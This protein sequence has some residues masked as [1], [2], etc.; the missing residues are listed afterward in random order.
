MSA[1][2]YT[3]TGTMAATTFSGSGA[4][5]TSIPRAGIANGT[6]DYVVINNGTGGLSSEA[7]LATSRGGLGSSWGAQAGGGVGNAAIAA[8]VGAATGTIT[9]LS[10]ATAA[11]AS[12][13]AIRDGSGNIA[14]NG[15]TVAQKLTIDN[16]TV[17]V[18]Y[19]IYTNPTVITTVGATSAALLTYSLLTPAHAKAVD[20]DLLVTANDVTHVANTASYRYLYRG[21]CVT[22]TMVLTLQP[23]ISSSVSYDATLATATIACTAS[24]SNFLVTVTGIALTTIVW[25]AV[26]KITQTYDLAGINEESSDDSCCCSVPQKVEPSLSEIDKA[27]KERLTAKLASFGITENAQSSSSSPHITISSAPVTLLSE[28]ER[29]ARARLAV[30]SIGT[31]INGKK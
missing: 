3:F 17:G 23:V 6:A 13:V 14:V 7:T 31:I 26:A 15:L 22:G 21:H 12:T 30:R 9:A 16:S 28:A 27:A 5:L 11:T 29:A 25:G 1:N 24:T 19:D 10:A 18:Y 4:S 20:I 2:T 8:V